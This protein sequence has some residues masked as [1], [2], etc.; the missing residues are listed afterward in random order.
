MN[1]IE[2]KSKYNE[3]KSKSEFKPY[4]ENIEQLKSEA[5]PKQYTELK[6]LLVG[7]SKNEGTLRERS[8][9]LLD[10]KMNQMKLSTSKESRAKLDKINELMTKAKIQHSRSIRHR[11]LKKKFN[12]TK[13]P[14]F[15]LI[16]PTKLSPI[17]EGSK[18]SE[19]PVWRNSPSPRKTKKNNWIFF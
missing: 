10:K 18:E 12:K 17:R 3:L 11:K 16:N 7:A 2:I 13:R 6:S 15:E 5:S 4:S 9:Q 1:E 8:L 19:S 14:R